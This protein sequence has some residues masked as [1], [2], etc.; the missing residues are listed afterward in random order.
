MNRFLLL[1]SLLLFKLNSFGQATLFEDNFENNV[2]GWTNYSDITPNYWITGVCAGNGSSAAGQ[3]T[4]YITFGGASGGCGPGGA[5]NYGFINSDNGGSKTAIFAHLIQATCASDIQVSY[6]QLLEVDNVDDFAEMVFSIDNGLT[7]TVVGTN[8]NSAVTWQNVS[9]N[10]PPSLNFTDFLLGFRFTY[11]ETNIGLKPLAVD[12]ILVTGTDSE[13]PIITCPATQTLYTNSSCAALVEDYVNL[14]TASDNCTTLSDL[15]FTQSPTIGTAISTNTTVQITVFDLSGNSGS[16]T[17]TLNALDTISPTINCQDSITINVNAL[18][19]YL[20]PDLTTA[21]TFSDNCTI[22]SNLIFT[23]NPIAGSTATGFTTITIN[24]ADAS[25]NEVSCSSVLVPNDTQAPSINCPSDI[26]LSNGTICSYTITDFTSL[27]TVAESC[28]NYTIQQAPAVNLEIGTGSHTVGFLVTDASGNSS[29]CTF[30]LNVLETI[31]PVFTNC[32]ATI[33]TCDPL[34]S[35]SEIFATDNCATVDIQQTDNTGFTSGSVFPA[36]ITAQQY[37]VTDLSGNT[38]VCN[39]NVE[40]YSYPSDA[41]IAIDSAEICANLTY[42]LV[43][44]PITNG[45]G[46]WTQITSASTIANPSNATTS[47]SNFSPGI[48]TYVWTVSTQNCGV[49]KDTIY[50]TVYSQ[51]TVVSI[52]TDS[53]Y[54]CNAQS[55]LLLGTFP[56][57]GTGVWTTLEGSTIVNP[58]QHNTVA[59]TLSPGWNTFIYTISNGTCL[60]S[61]D[62]LNV[63][64]NNLALIQSNDTTVCITDLFEIQGDVPVAGQTSAWYFIK[65]KGDILTPNSPNSFVDNIIS[66]ENIIVY[67]LSHPV[68]GFSHDTLRITVNNCTGEEFVFPTVITPNSDG[69]NDAFYV[70][71]LNVLY[72]NCEVVIV[73]RWG[74]VVFES[75]GYN[76]PWNG[77]FKGEELPMGT[78]YYKIL[79]NDSEKQSYTGPIS[80]IR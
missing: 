14:A 11:N 7:W 64:S 58:T 74:T 17:F 22:N 80:I 65:G 13:D 44:N 53:A 46:A 29:T 18:C 79:L 30:T 34:V 25:G 68:C 19:Q 75:V 4:M 9:T 41:I 50:V 49:K 47:V 12:N 5:S 28:P 16:C 31:Q 60:A 45:I 73:N 20:V 37:T 48:N 77:I 33:I 2:A 69:K 42:D 24:V 35:Y 3:T 32:P 43:A 78:Y 54:I 76:T 67:R 40:V 6:D 52:Q 71:N 21:M 15:T 10:L 72:P 39:F 8:L 51:P 1:I 70:D 63:Y 26:T 62:T 38:A 23:Q 66:G 57:S 56:T 55:T 61:D 36:G 59:N 27:V